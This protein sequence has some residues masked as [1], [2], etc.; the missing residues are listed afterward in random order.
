MVDYI[1]TQNAY[2]IVTIEDPIEYTFRDKRSVVNQREIGFDTQ[3]FSRALRAALRQDPD[4]VLVGE[5]RDQRD[6]VDRHDRGRDRPPGAVDPAH[7]RR[8]RDRQPDHLDVPE[9]T[10][11]SRPA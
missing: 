7:L 11:R 3:S 6:R 2:H 9:P 1:N 10:S 4:V 8:H 5:M